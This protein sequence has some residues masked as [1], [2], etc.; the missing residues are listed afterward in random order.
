MQ[1][2]DYKKKYMELRS[3]YINDLD[4]A[5]RLGVEQG[6]QVA[7]QQ[8]T[9]DK[10]AQMN[11]EKMQMQQASQGQP[12]GAPGADA[13]EAPPDPASE[14]PTSAESMQSEQRGSELDQHI[15]KLES[16]IGSDAKPE[17]KKSLDAIVSLRKAEKDAVDMKKSQAAISGI[18]KALH[19]PSFKLGVQATHNLSENGK[20]A[21]STQHKIVTDIMKSWEK[22]EEKAKNS[23]ENILNI[24]NLIKE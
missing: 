12:P 7:Q 16:M 11:E 14:N 13:G 9:Q 3:K 22:E 10:E 19:K 8:Q 18:V 17:I 4:M 21:L 6:I 1:G 24:E 5:F 20:K 15:G 23:I 2:P